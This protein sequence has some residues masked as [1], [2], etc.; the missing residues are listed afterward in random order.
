MTKYLCGARAH[1]REYMYTH[2]IGLGYASIKGSLLWI[3]YLRNV[4]RPLDYENLVVFQRL[5]EQYRR[6]NLRMGRHLE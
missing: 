2:G 6:E 5:D 1:A 3:A 4:S